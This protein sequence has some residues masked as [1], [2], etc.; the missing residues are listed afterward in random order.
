MPYL[1]AVGK[2][3]DNFK[4]LEYKKDENV[5]GYLY[6]VTEIVS[7]SIYK[8][9]I[10]SLKY[11]FVDFSMLH[12]QTYCLIRIQRKY[13]SIF[14]VEDKFERIIEETKKSKLEK[15]KRDEIIKLIEDAIQEFKNEKTASDG[16]QLDLHQKEEQSST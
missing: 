3:F 8:L 15:S 9:T 5:W 2:S 10:E 13:H 6:F 7:N 1:V 16:E 4:Y 12:Q 14:H 11:N